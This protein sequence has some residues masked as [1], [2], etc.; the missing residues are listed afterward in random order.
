MHASSTTRFNQSWPSIY[1]NQSNIIFCIVCWV[2]IGPCMWACACM[3]LL[4]EV[5][6]G[7]Y[8]MCMLAYVVFFLYFGPYSLY[9][10]NVMCGTCHTH[11]CL[12]QF[13]YNYFI[14]IY[15]RNPSMAGAYMAG[16]KITPRPPFPRTVLAT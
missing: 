13:C 4:W 3:L 1:I 15:Y 14:T 16:G 6:Y 7:V 10:P 12:T 9:F 11:I 8:C 5:L 2:P